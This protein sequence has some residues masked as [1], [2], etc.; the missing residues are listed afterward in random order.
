[1]THITCRMTTKNR[2]LLQNPALGNRVLATFTFFNTSWFFIN[3]DFSLITTHISHWRHFSDIHISQGSVATS[4][5]CGWIFKHDFVDNLLPSPSAKEVWKAVNIWR[6]CEK[7]FGVLFFWLSVCIENL[8]FV[9]LLKLSKY[10]KIR[11]YCKLEEIGSAKL[12]NEEELAPKC[13]KMNSVLS[14]AFRK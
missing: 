9:C 2:D 13:R 14:V 10:R 11:K 6:S 4:L 8:I 5:R 3:R 7:E 12:D 1:M